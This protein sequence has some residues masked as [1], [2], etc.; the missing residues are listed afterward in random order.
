MSDM[1]R[2]GGIATFA[3][4]PRLEDVDGADVA[5]LVGVGGLEQ[6]GHEIR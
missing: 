4:L 5:V 3:L 1:P 6:F 2:Y